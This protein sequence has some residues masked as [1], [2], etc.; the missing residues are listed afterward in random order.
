MVY[1]KGTKVT[2]TGTRATISPLN[3]TPMVAHV[4]RSIAALDESHFCPIEVASVPGSL[5]Y[6]CAILRARGGRDWERGYYRGQLR[7]LSG[8]SF[9][10]V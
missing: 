4:G 1:L 2:T 6:A 3:L 7:I 8:S 5:P 9:I 10:V